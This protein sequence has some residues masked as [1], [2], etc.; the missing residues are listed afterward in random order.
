MTERVIAGNTRDGQLICKGMDKY[1]GTCVV[2]R[3]TLRKLF[4]GRRCAVQVEWSRWMEQCSADEVRRIDKA[5]EEA[6]ASTASAAKP[7]SR[8]AQPKLYALSVVGG[9]PLYAFDDEDKAFAVCDALTEAAKASG[10]AAKYDVMELR[11]W[12]E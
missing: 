6:M 9:A 4:R 2:G 12:S 3:K 1:E 7:A 5:K 11:R 8:A 10:F